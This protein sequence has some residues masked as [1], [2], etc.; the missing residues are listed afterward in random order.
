MEVI[1][2]RTDDD[3][4]NLTH[5]MDDPAV[6]TF[7]SRRPGPGSSKKVSSRSSR[8]SLRPL[9]YHH[10]VPARLLQFYREGNRKGSGKQRKSSGSL[11]FSLSSPRS[12]GRHVMDSRVLGFDTTDRLGLPV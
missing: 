9:C 8:A 1:P 6:Y 2:N 5:L 4:T 7:L 12:M 11:S 3:T 10:Q